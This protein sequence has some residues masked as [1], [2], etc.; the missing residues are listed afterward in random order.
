MRSN[1]LNVNIRSL[2]LDMDG[3]LWRDVEPI[4]NLE[5]I[6]STISQGGFSFVLATNNSTLSAAQYVRK[7][8][9][10]GVDV[11]IEQVVNSS[12]AT[13]HFLREISPDGGPVYII[14][15]QGLEGALN[16]Y[17]FYHQESDVEYVVVGLDR[18]LSYENL[19]KATLLINNNVPLIA[20]NPDKTFPTPDGL[21]P[22][23]G[24]IVAAL[25][26]ATQAKAEVIGKP[27]PIMYQVAIDRLNSQPAQTLVIGDRL[28]T[29]IL[30]AQKLGCP[31]AL[32][33]SGVTDEDKAKAWNPLP[34]IIARDLDE[35]INIIVG[36]GLVGY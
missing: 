15:E 11:E 9:S 17:G 35:V 21:V 12:Q 16:D 34:D 14:G 30:G 25:E 20:T 10:F 18:R 36:D 19:A 24:A 28:E 2:I 8:N 1:V 33:L 29:D 13:A 4:G 31:T 7:L 3:V 32:V 23:A 26:A 6:F 22:G 5:A 27:S